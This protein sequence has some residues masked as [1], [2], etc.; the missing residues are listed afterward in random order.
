MPV[1]MFLIVAGAILL[2][3]LLAFAFK[4]FGKFTMRLYDDVVDA[5]TEEDVTLCVDKEDN[6]KES[7]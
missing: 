3:F 7:N 6:E 2:W 5:M 1:L 4:P